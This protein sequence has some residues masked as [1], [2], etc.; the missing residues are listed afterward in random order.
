MLLI[1][2]GLT[3]IAFASAFCLP[4]FGH[5]SFSKIEHG[6]TYLARRK[7]VAIAVGAALI[8]LRLAILPFCPIPHPFVPD[9]FSFLLAAKTFASGRL[10]NPTPLMWIHFESIHITMVPTYMSMYFP[11]QGLAMAAG[12]V[13]F[14]NFWFGIL[15]CSGLMCAALCWALQAWLPPAWALLGGVIAVL[16][17]GLFSYWT[18]TYSGGG[19]IAALGG[20]LVVGALPRFMRTPRMRYG[21]LMAIG[22]V[23]LALSRPYEGLLLCLPVAAVL[24]RWMLTGRNRPPARTLLR[25]AAAPMAILV[26]A[27]VWYG[28]YNDRVF[29]NPLTLPYQVNRAEYAM[30]PYFVWQKQRPQ[31]A[32]RHAMMRKF[33][34]QDELDVF[35]RIH[36]KTGFMPQTLRKAARGILFYTGIVLLVPLIML[37]RVLLDRRIRFMVLCV[38]ILMAGLLIEIFLIPHYIAPFTVAFYVIG[39]QAMRHLRLWRPEGQPVG[40]AL[41]RFVVTLCFVLG[42]IRLFAAPLH[43][44]LPA[45]P[46]AWASEWYGMTPTGGERAR[47]QAELDRLPGKQLALVRYSPRHNPANEWV[48]NDPDLNN[49]KVIW[50]WDMGPEKNRELLQYYQDRHLWLVQP[51]SYPAI[52]PYVPPQKAIP[53]VMANQGM[54]SVMPERSS[55]ESRP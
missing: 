21:V 30:A 45:W 6:F 17:I 55:K 40:R 49:S 2:G 16:R 42:G 34:Y 36:S 8:L 44:A 43:I 18:N 37:R 38:A 51:D 52:S 13:L 31:P 48:Y 14:G 3:L 20:A 46:A 12:K 5:T 29:G 4:R 28:Y 41:V 24:G 53:V 9:D 32:Y 23:L 1:E 19:S 33:Y 7:N 10:T 26:I 50:A 11:A 25:L 39:L 47:I 27:G 35:R 54:V 15:L 22:A